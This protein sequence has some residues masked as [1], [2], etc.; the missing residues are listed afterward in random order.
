MLFHFPRKL[1]TCS[2]RRR[3]Q[4]PRKQRNFNFFSLHNEVSYNLWNDGSRISRSHS[5]R[6]SPETSVFSKDVSRR[7]VHE[8]SY[9]FTNDYCLVTKRSHLLPFW[10]IPLRSHSKPC[11]RI[12]M[13]IYLMKSS[14]TRL[15]FFLYSITKLLI[16]IAYIL[17]NKNLYSDI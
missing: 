12:V 14:L 13:C 8:H 17:D 11:G 5:R 15:Y 16:V 9:I 1:S 2:M 7:T 4:E 6:L 10:F 3:A